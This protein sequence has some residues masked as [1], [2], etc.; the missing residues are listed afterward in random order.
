[1]LY[2][3]LWKKKCKWDAK[4]KAYLTTPRATIDTLERILAKKVEQI[5][6]LPAG[7]IDQTV[8]DGLVKL[9]AAVRRARKEEHFRSQAINV[10]SRFGPF[11]RDREKEKYKV[12]WLSK[13]MKAF[14]ED[15]RDDQ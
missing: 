5:N 10:M 14:F 13:M 1:M 15:I 6:E 3:V 12:E 7:E 11:V 4:R 2:Y 8:A 9:M